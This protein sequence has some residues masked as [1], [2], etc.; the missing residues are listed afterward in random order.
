MYKKHYDDVAKELN[1]NVKS[2]L[3]SDE[4]ASRREKYGPNALEEH[5]KETL[6]VKFF[7]EFADVLIIILLVAAA[8]SLIVD[9]H[10]WVDAL[11]I[12]IVVMLNAVLGVVQEA[13]AEKSLEALKK[14]SS[15]E[16]KVIRNG[17]T[18]K[19][20]STELVVGDIILIEA[21]DFIPADARIIDAVNLQVD[22]S[23]LTGES[24]PVTKMTDVID[25]DVTALGDRKNMLFSS[26]FVTNGRGK[27]IVTDTGMKTEIGKIAGMLGAQK[28]EPTPLQNKLTQVGSV[29][30]IISIFIC[31]G[32]FAL[33]FFVL[34]GMQVEHLVESFK[35]AVALAVAAIP[36][37]LATVV[38]IVLAIGVSKMVKE[39]A[40]V[41]KLPAVETLGCTSIVCS[42]KTGTLTQNKM[43]V[44]EVY[45]NDKL[46]LLSDIDSSDY[47]LLNY[48][49]ICCDAKIEMIDGVEKRIGDPTETALVELNN[50]YG[51]DISW[52]E[53]VGEIPFDSDRKLMTVVIKKDGKFISIT[54]GAPDILLK[55]LK[56]E[57]KLEDIKK[58]VNDMSE[59][60]LRV[61][62]LGIKTFD[63]M[64][65]V[66]SSL[67]TELE[68]VGLGGMIDPPRPEVMDAI[69]V[70]KR[71][72]VRTIMITGDNI[73]TATA[74]AKQLGIMDE[75]QRA[76]GSDELDAM[77]DEELNERIAEF[78]VY[79]RVAPKDKV[80]IVEAWQ[81][82]GKVVAMTGDGVN[83]SPALK[84]AD[85]G[86]AMG[87]TGTDV[88]K[89]AADM[90][91]T[92]DNFTT[93]IKAVKQGRGIYANIR[94]CVKYLL[95]SNIGEV[96]V[97]L[98]AE[99]IAAFGL[100]KGMS[101]PLASI[102]LLWI[103]LVTDSLP[104]FGLG[105]EKPEDG[106]MLET[107]RPKDENFFAQKLGL[108]IALEGVVVGLLTL[109]SYL[110]GVILYGHVVGS[111]MAFVTLA[112]TQLFHSYNV[113][114]DASV[115]S[116]K[117]F[118]NR[119]LNL[120]FIVGAVMQL[121]VVYIP[122]LNTVFESVMLNF[123][124]IGIA[125]GFAF[126]IVIIMEIYKLIAK[127]VKKSK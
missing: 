22:E 100:V 15:P 40:I 78:S 51:S 1:S 63:S 5:K 77:S 68:F 82:K 126:A 102:H 104:A 30:G 125:I 44:L 35:L 108:H 106:V 72:G 34:N 116:K 45:S 65:E 118:D 36:E 12:F 54:K 61:L 48:F 73:I 95:S 101:I 38:T 127:L 89:E 53:R 67:E 31:L 80:R 88:S 10:E 70:A 9:I 28:A 46:K 76:V 55:R 3:N 98:L 43:T 96:L 33:D 107:P 2:G 13:K 60:A 11:V 14:M 122:G 21:G 120:A 92:D 59:K 103:N 119:F 64:P 94:K 110:L 123:A 74:I 93:I 62:A 117:T 49:S 58:A 52:A 81:S 99:V 17:V 114:S 66:N 18:D 75:G 24:V 16:C 113:K 37:G 84:K 90:I 91:L 105:M 111:T 86:C 29:I 47:S 19:I 112:F 6:L 26:T 50:K 97:I 27:A 57:S 41:K 109:G 79:A 32:V 4:V 124:Q 42:D 8:I 23:A 56:D 39:N 85:I 20:P 25:G 7:K 87:I 115:I 83:D 71:A 121:A 69:K